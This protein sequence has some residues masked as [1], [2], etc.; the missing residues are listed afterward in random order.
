VQEEI[1]GMLVPEKSPVSW[2]L[3]PWVVY[4]INRRCLL[5]RFTRRWQTE[6][7]ADVRSKTW[8]CVL[9][10][11]WRVSSRTR[12]FLTV[13][14]RILHFYESRLRICRKCVS[15]WRV[16]SSLVAHWKVLKLDWCLR[17]TGHLARVLW[18]THWCL[19]PVRSAEN[20]KDYRTTR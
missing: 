2:N 17:W 13:H 7:V 16:L 18:S 6:A 8:N 12:P 4:Q 19:E 1:A 9:S 20:C 5:F 11:T 10:R 15:G 14:E 3:F